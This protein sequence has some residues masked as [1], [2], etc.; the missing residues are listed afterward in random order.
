MQ[1]GKLCLLT[2]LAV[3]TTG[4]VAQT[5]VTTSGGT[6]NTVPLF[7]GG[8]TIGNSLMTQ[9]TSTPPGGT[10]AIPSLFMS[11]RLYLANPGNVLTMRGLA[12]TSWTYDIRNDQVGALTFQSEAPS[13]APFAIDQLGN[14]G[15]GTTTPKAALDVSTGIIHV[16]GQANPT[17]TG[18]GAYLGWNMTGGQGET[19]FINNQ[20]GGPGGFYFVNVPASGGPQTRV[21][22]VGPTGTVTLGAG[23]S[24]VF[25]D[26]SAQSTAFNSS[27]PCIAGGDYAESVDVT[28]ARGQYEPGDVMGI[29]PEHSG[30]YLKV[31]AAYSTLVAGVYSTKPG[32]VGR[33][34]PASKPKDGEV[35][36]AMVGIVPTKVSA[37]NGPI[38][39]GDLLV[40][41]STPGHAMKGTDRT[42]LTGAVVG[43]A[44][45]NLESG[46]GIIE[47]MITLQ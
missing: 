5:T 21:L 3:A 32:F 4:L 17:T 10:S 13:S 26:G 42:L 14:I 6:A 31:Q 19:D 36:M 9:G 33:R 35:P 11:E 27:T 7:T 47:A 25:P 2:T 22:T 23:A 15:I 43:K 41:S 40:S 44:L 38:H 18:Q 20:G 29:D 8:A 37:E 28:G 45:D 12:N 46:T 34:Q 16:A 24:L 39:V 30:N 1:M